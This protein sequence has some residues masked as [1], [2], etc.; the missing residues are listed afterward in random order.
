MT[1]R[2][3]RRALV[4]VLAVLAFALAPASSGPA[5]AGPDI[6][7][8]QQ[9]EPDEENVAIGPR[10][11]AQFTLLQLNDV[12][13]TQPVNGAGGLARVATLKRRVAAEGRPALLVVAGDFLS[14][15]VASSVFKGEQMIAAL[16]AA[17]VDYATLGN[18][19]FDFGED[20]LVQRMAEAKFTWIVSNVVDRRTGK[21]IGN[22][23]PWVLRTI[24]GV[25]V[26]FIGL[27]LNTTEISPDKLTE[28][29]ITDPIETA[30]RDVAL[31]KQRG[32]A[33]VVALTHL[34]FRDDRRLV[35]RVPAIDLIVGGH[36]HYP[37]AATEGRTFIS[38]AG[39]DAKWL[40]RIDVGR[41]SSGTVERLYELLAVGAETPDDPTTAAAVK[42]YEDRLSAELNAVVGATTVPLA[43]DTPRI[44]TAET[45]LGDL[46]ADIARERVGADVALINA[47]SIR[48]DRVYPAGPLTRRTLVDIHPFGNVICAVE[49]PGRVLA[50]ALENGAA[51]LPDTAGQFPQVSGMTLTIDPKAP[52]GSRV[53]D[54]RV[55][56]APLD[57][58]RTYRL[59][60]PDYL[61]KGGD[62]YSMFATARV[63]VSP[64]D[65]DSMLA[66]LERYVAEKKTIAPVTDGRIMIVR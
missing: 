54:V 41:R 26:G 45:N 63:L 16:N 10:A 44:R 43:A 12:Y 48:G 37:I 19:E 34:A 46:V 30:A 24:G 15:S 7:F 9:R 4:F 29:R 1:T 11:G 17:G 52:S 13:S 40:A 55:N 28:I 6:L 32:A 53:R 50:Q 64:E 35:A 8:A 65:G 36:E 25:K 47:G 31:L 38:K 20:V 61:L 22:A 60:I 42:S 18:H 21:P 33:V 66:V 62:D 58:A 51:K 39:S 57:P 27:C 56:G 49:V 14:P 59:A 2:N 3:T 23:V 5:K